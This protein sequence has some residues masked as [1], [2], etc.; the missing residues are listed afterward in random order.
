[1]AETETDTCP[2]TATAQEAGPDADP[3]AVAL[4]RTRVAIEQR[5]FADALADNIARDLLNRRRR[6]GLGELT[7]VSTRPIGSGEWLVTSRLRIP[8][9]NDQTVAWRVRTT[10][11]GP[12]VS[13]VRSS[14]TSMIRALRNEYEPALRRLGLDRLIGR[15]EARGDEER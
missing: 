3:T 6:Y 10:S 11:R 9:R 7:L 12:V 1:M 13:D 14:G 4:R 5:R 2:A 8:S 15:M